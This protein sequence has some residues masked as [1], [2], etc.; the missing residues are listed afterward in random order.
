MARALTV[1]FAGQ[2]NGRLLIRYGGV[3]MDFDDMAAVRE[4]M[5]SKLGGDEGGD[6]IL[7][8]LG[9]AHSFASGNPNSIV[10]KTIT[11]NASLANNIVRVT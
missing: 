1:S 11:F 5:R 8:A 3:E 7:L 6:E 4:W 9:M 2:V 10:G